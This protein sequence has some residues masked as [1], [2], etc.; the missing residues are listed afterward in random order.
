MQ[1]ERK[2]QLFA[3]RV[4]SVHR[5]V[6]GLAILA[7]GLVPINWDALGGSP[8]LGP[9]PP[10]A[11]VPIVAATAW[12]LA[13]AWLH[14]EL[15]RPREYRLTLGS[16]ASRIHLLTDSLLA[17]V[18][19]AIIWRGHESPL[20]GVRVWTICPAV[21]AIGVLSAVALSL[22]RMNV[23]RGSSDPARAMRNWQWMVQTRAILAGLLILILAGL[24]VWP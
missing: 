24:S 10:R 11:I 6:S 14:H 15:A 1:L 7:A 9:W 4:T 16:G 3:T 12:F 18:A 23:P 2:P 19:G 21:L 13:T 22:D 5:A 8:V 17:G 20:S